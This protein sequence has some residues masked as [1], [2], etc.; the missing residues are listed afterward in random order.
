MTK[1]RQAPPNHFKGMDRISIHEDTDG[2]GV[3]DQHKIFVDELNIAFVIR[4]GSR[5]SLCHESSVSLV[6]S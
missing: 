3:Y 6:L 2:D 1:F 4:G 5:R